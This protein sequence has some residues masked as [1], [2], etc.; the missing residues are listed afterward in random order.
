LAPVRERIR[1]PDVGVVF[2]AN[3]ISTKQPGSWC[4]GGL[5][6]VTVA[7]VSASG[8]KFSMDSSIVVHVVASRLGGA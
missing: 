3:S 2:P 6:A 5:V 1:E 4:S 8:P 7:T